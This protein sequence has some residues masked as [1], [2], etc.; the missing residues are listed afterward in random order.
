MAIDH[1]AEDCITQQS[2]LNYTNLNGKENPL[3]T[4]LKDRE[5][6]SGWIDC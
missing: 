3:H 2:E 5:G 1:R 6:D 4:G